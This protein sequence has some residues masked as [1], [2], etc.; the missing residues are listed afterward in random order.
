MIL[1]YFGKLPNYF[2]FWIQSVKS[3]STIDW[4][5]FTDNVIQDYPK[6]LKVVNLKFE[7]FKLKFNDYF[8]FDI[9]LPS[10]YKLCDF[11]IVY[12]LVL[13]EYVV[14]YDFWGFCDCDLIWGN[15]RKFISN[16]LLNRYD[17]L[18]GLGPFQL[19]KVNDPYYEK[20]LMNAKA[21]GKFNFQHVFTHGKNFV[22]DE[23]PHGVPYQYYI[24][25]KEKYFNEFSN[26]ERP[27]D[28]PHPD[29]YH[30]IDGYNSVQE[31]GKAYEKTMFYQ[32]K[33]KVDFWNRNINS[34]ISPRQSHFIYRY[35][36]GSLERYYL[37]NGKL[38]KKEI[39][40]V[41]FRSRN[42][43]LKTKNVLDYFVIP[44]KFI[45]ASSE[46]NALFMRFNG[47]K[48]IFNWQKVNIKY[49]KKVLTEKLLRRI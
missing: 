46:P 27:Y 35:T 6:N 16:D 15:I 17:H 23:L 37:E 20:I 9:S 5:L 26:D 43:K 4:L 7:D 45:T 33:G 24:E 1:P 49:L 2:D 28:S 40:Y 14:N 3:N 42:F 30:F 13:K 25:R 32:F 47:R 38:N 21:K 41:H 18:F 10:P 31:L 48:R 22:F 11:K 36:N 39:M 12:G 29:Y 44:N 8:S 34:K 19:Q